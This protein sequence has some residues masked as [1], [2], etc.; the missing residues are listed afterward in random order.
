MDYTKP[1]KEILIDLINQ[2]NGTALRVQDVEISEPRV[3][4]DNVLKTN[5]A[6]TLSSATGSG[7]FGNRDIFYSRLDIREILESKPL[8]VQPIIETTLIE[9]LPAINEAYG[10][11]LKAED[12]YDVVI[13]PYDPLHPNAIR[14]ISLV[15][16]P[17]SYFY[18]GTFDLVFGTYN[19]AITEVDGVT[20]TYLLVI[21]GYPINR[22]KESFIALNVDGSANT[23]FSFLSNVTT[24][25]AWTLDKVY[26]LANEQFVLEGSF[27]IIYTDGSNNVHDVTNKTQ[28]LISETGAV[29]ST[30]DTKRFVFG[31]NSKVFDTVG[32]PFKYFIDP[33]NPSRDSHLFRYTDAGVLDNTF[34]PAIDYQPKFIRITPDN[35]IYSVSNVYD[36]ADPG[37]NNQLTKLIRIDRMLATGALD[38]TFNTIYIRSSLPTFNP[39]LVTDLCPNDAQG[40]YLSFASNG[41]LDSSSNTPVINTVSLVNVDILAQAVYSWSPIVRFE[42]DG[43]LDKSF[44]TSHNG[45]RG[46]TLY[47]PSGSPITW[48]TKGII[49][50]GEKSY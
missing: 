36:G 19:N 24:I 23:A 44:K 13:P 11:F 15:I 49:A 32:I 26:R 2:K 27:S 43:E 39:P 31:D 42:A 9:F 4:N 16:S 22:V 5:T 3:F 25:N 38:T 30:S 28:I 35:K 40:F 46:H 45:R 41:G 17:S 18:I 47:E 29:I 8:E 21:D 1:T 10:T 33:D 48:D 14:T 20:R 50:E 34:L 12:I 7:Y 37:N 6:V